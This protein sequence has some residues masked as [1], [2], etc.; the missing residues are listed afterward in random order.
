MTPNISTLFK[1]DLEN[2][3]SPDPQNT[4]LDDSCNN[5]TYKKLTCW[6]LLLSPPHQWYYV[7]TTDTNGSGAGWY[8]VPYVPKKQFWIIAV[9]GWYSIFSHA[10]PWAASFSNAVNTTEENKDSPEERRSAYFWHWHYFFFLFSFFCQL[11]KINAWP[12]GKIAV[13]KTT[14]NELNKSASLTLLRRAAISRNDSFVC[15]CVHTHTHIYICIYVC[16][17]VCMY[18]YIY[19]YIYIYME[20]LCKN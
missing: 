15:L 17:Y 14:T 1:C 11:P 3:N 6:F 7:C 19:I 16:M 5:S 12:T 10:F 8:N 18:I 4:N 9:P 2:S 20:F 13:H